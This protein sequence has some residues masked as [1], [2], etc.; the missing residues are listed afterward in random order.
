MK[1]VRALA[2][3]LER[4]DDREERRQEGMVGARK[5]THGWCCQF[6]IFLYDIDLYGGQGT[7]ISSFHLPSS[8]SFA[9]LSSPVFVFISCL[10]FRLHLHCH[11]LA[12]SCSSLAYPIFKKSEFLCRP[13]ASHIKLHVTHPLRHHPTSHTSP[14]IIQHHLHLH[15]PPLS[16]DHHYHSTSI[17]L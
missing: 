10:R 15:F 11:M 14:L 5:G 17:S 6:C 16:P 2:Q 4:A 9:H 1:G 13:Y 7:R 12:V 3:V 8:S